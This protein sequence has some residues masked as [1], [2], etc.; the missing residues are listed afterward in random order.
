MAA[1]LAASFRA[2]PV[3]WILAAVLLVA[4]GVFGAVQLNKRI[5]EDAYVTAVRTD[6]RARLSPDLTDDTLREGLA[7]QCKKIAEGMT[8][9][10][11]VATG[12]RDWSSVGGGA[13]VSRE[14]FIAN[15]I[16]FFEAAKPNC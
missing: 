1:S 3:I 2:H 5:R 10:R 16:V 6:P 7:Y 15:G 8:V 4:L 9:D 12:V 14:Q 11:L 13:P